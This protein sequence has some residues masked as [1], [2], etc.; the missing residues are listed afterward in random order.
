MVFVKTAPLL[1]LATVDETSVIQLGI[2]YVV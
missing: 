1:L 2:F